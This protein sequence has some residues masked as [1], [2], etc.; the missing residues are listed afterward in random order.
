MAGSPLSWLLIKTFS[1]INRVVPWYR[2]PKPLAVLNLVAIR[3]T[4]RQRNLHDT[5][6]TMSTP[7]PELTAEQQ[8]YRTARTVD[9]T[10]NDLKYP[11]MGSVGTRFARNVP[12]KF[13]FPDAPAALLTPN[14]RTVSARLLARDTF[15]PATSLNVLAAAWIQFQ[16]HDWFNHGMPEPENPWELPLD[17]ADPWPERPMRIGRTRRDPTYAPEG[18]DRG[19]PPTSINTSV[20]WWDA[21]QIY[22]N[23]AEAQASLRSGDKGKLI[24]GADGLLPLDPKTGTDRTGIN[25]NWWVGLSLLHT[26]FTK[27]HN[28]ICDRLAAE[29]PDWSDD[30]VFDR[31]RLINGALM[32]KIHTVEWTPGILAQPTLRFAMRGNWWGLMGERF[33]RGFGRLGRSDFLGGIPGSLTAHHGAPYAMTEEFTAVYRLHP[34]IPDDFN[35][36]SLDGDRSLLDQTFPDV[37]GRNVRKLQSQIAMPD[38]FYSLGSSNPG[39]V[40]LHNFPRFLRQLKQPT[41]ALVDLAAVDVLRDRERG[42]P[43]YNQFRQL[44]HKPR[45]KSF[46]QLTKNRVWAEEL[47]EVYDNDVDRVDTMVGMYA[48]PTPRGFGFSDTAF[49][50][51][52]LMASRRL[53]SDRFFTTDYTP[54]VYTKLGMDWIDNNTMSTVLLRHYPSL[55]PFLGQ[56]NNAFAPWPRKAR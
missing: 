16:V 47:R 41:G 26:L 52:V 8:R 17:Q 30:Q 22:G 33:H 7:G 48:E 24:V 37:E 29:Y 53:K 15:I 4:L 19:L 44:L 11:T 40:T 38:L 25:D 28:A 10:L 3:D 14:P 50:I 5:T 51:F 32:A 1:G 42:V 13:G 23:T 31:A 6:G 35:F 27:E 20:H 18:K 12:L 43:R 54:A 9:G 45:V 49:R 36:R 46:E 34:L 21:S 2:L 39:A 55:A 56:V